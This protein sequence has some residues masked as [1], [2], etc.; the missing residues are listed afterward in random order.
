M[1]A[2]NRRLVHLERRR[3]LLNGGDRH[4]PIACFRYQVSTFTKGL[5][6]RP[7]DEGFIIYDQDG[8]W[9]I[10]HDGWNIPHI[11]FRFSPGRFDSG[12]IS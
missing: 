4:P 12:Q 3:R 1:D 9:G 11:P 10:F 6:Q 8:R 2:G 7:P 5:R